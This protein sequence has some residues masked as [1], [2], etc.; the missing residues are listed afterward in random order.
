VLTLGSFSCRFIC[1]KML[2]DLIALI[3]IVTEYLLWWQWFKWKCLSISHRNSRW[4]MS[5]VTVK[6]GQNR[7][8][9]CTVLKCVDTVDSYCEVCDF[10]QCAVLYQCTACLE[11]CCCTECYD[12]GCA[13]S[14]N[15]VLSAVHVGIAVCWVARIHI[16]SVNYYSVWCIWRVRLCNLTELLSASTVFLLAY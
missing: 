1:S 5:G 11:S 4:E 9:Y 13:C 15:D 16:F 2:L 14:T 12:C 7:S 8:C 3:L 6:T 10:W